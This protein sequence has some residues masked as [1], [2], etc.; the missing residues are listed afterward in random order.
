M[1]VE[2]LGLR[3]KIFRRSQ[4]VIL[5]NQQPG[6]GYL[7]CPNMPDYNFSWFRDGAFIAYALTIDGLHA[8][9]QRPN[10]VAAQWDSALRFHDWC[11]RMINDRAEALE[12]TIERAT[13]GEP[14]VLADTINARYTAGGVPGPDG[15]PEFQ[16]DGPA[17]WL[18]SLAKYAEV[19]RMKRP[20]PVIWET[21]IERA[22]RYLAALW[23]TPCYDCWE[24]RGSDIH[25]S[26]LAAIYA[27]LGA[28]QSLVPRLDYV[29]VREA[30]RRLILTEGM[31]PSRELAKSLHLDM[32]DA[33]LLFAALPGFG[34]LAPD[35]PLMLR[36]VA[37]IE[38]DLL[39]EGHGVHRHRED[40]YY[41]GGAWV[42]LGLWLAWYDQQVGRNAEAERL[43]AW[44]EAH[45]DADGNLPEQVNDAMLDTR[46]YDGWVEQRGVIASPLLWTHAKYLL[47][48]HGFAE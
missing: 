24:E 29:E 26:T 22:A 10:D 28:A 34:L 30:I 37:R 14:P 48:Y 2:Q 46:C 42:L 36:T 23:Q 17:V 47:V 11:A 32:F 7:A 31:T 13:R 16:L 3:D 20:L 33:N 44:A 9:I 25:V 39:A 45:A 4:Q 1:K 21:A 8:P 19:C 15:W 43:F 35:D 40:T 12:R 41:G 18:W 27:G 5:E 6:G 38:R